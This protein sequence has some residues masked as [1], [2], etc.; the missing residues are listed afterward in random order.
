MQARI[1]EK[2]KNCWIVNAQGQRY[3]ARVGGGKIKRAK[4]MLTGDFV[5]IDPGHGVGKDEA[6][7]VSLLPRKNALFRP[8]IANVEH[9]VCLCSPK[10]PPFS[11]DLVQRAL[12]LAQFHSIGFSVVLNKSDLLDEHSAHPIKA[13][14]DYFASQLAVNVVYSSAL[15]GKIPTSE[16]F[17][18]QSAT[19][20][21]TGPSGVGKSTLL[22]EL[23]SGYDPQTNKVSA[24]TDRGVH[25][26]TSVQLLQLKNGRTWVADSPGYTAHDLPDIAFE[27]LRSYFTD[28]DG[29]SEQCR[30]ANCRHLTEPD[31]AVREYFLASS[32]RSFR[33]R[34]YESYYQLLWQ[35]QQR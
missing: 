24:G 9:L 1:I 13:V 21:F 22:S 31:C 5:E 25:T 19:Y 10:S 4:K 32:I 17:E 35:R 7:I 27:Q 2:H 12:L 16:L 26:T 28:F 15:Q 18:Q 14:L 23:V 20:C 8:A 6:T 3:I 33:Y 30:F 29:P 34:A 11:A